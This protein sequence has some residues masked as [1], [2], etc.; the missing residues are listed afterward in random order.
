MTPNNKHRDRIKELRRVRAGDLSPNPRNWRVHPE[1][2]VN[3]MRGILSEIGFADALLARELD[4]GTL[5]LV[6]GH[7]R[8]AL[9][10]EQEVPVLILDLDQDEAHKLMVA[11]DPMAAMAEADKDL[12]GQLLAEIQTE[13]EGL[14]AMFDDLVADEGIDTNKVESSE[15]YTE[16]T[17][18]RQL[19]VLATC[20]DETEQEKAYQLLSEAGIECRCLTL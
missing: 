5:E 19:G 18:S 6:D 10:S 16:D 4:D 12:L 14:Q 1:S 13:N 20:S 17:S 11:L 3:A 9:D 2:Q 8:Q 15:D 7:L